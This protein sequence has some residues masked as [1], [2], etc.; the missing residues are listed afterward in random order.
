MKAPSV[1]LDAPG[2]VARRHGIHHLTDLDHSSDR[3]RDHSTDEKARAAT[4]A[5]TTAVTSP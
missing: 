4:Q 2:S 1:L 3:V 5:T